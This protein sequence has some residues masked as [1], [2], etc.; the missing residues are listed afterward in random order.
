[1][2]NSYTKAM[3]PVCLTLPFDVRDS[4]LLGYY[5]KKRVIKENPVKYDAIIKMETRTIKKNILKPKENA[6]CSYHIHFKKP[7]VIEICHYSE[8]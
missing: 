1:M 4:K 2:K 6:H 8:K 5:L 7:F 3:P